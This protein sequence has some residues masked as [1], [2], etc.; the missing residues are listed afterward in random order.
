MYKKKV[1]CIKPSKGSTIQEQA[2]DCFYSIEKSLKENQVDIRNV[3]KQTIFI[4][5]VDNKHFYARK[6][7]LLIA[8]EGFYKSLLPPTGIVGQLP[9][10]DIFLAIELTL[11]ANRRK[12]IKISRK[13]V[14]G[15]RYLTVQYP[16]FKE[17]Y[18]AGLTAGETCT[19]RLLQAKEAFEQMKKILENENLNF[20]DV[21]RQWNY[22][23]NITGSTIL[24][25]GEKQNYQI[26]NDT[27]AIYYGRSTFKNGYPAAT[28]IGMN[29]GGVILEFIAVEGSKDMAI[30][31][32]KNPDQVDAHQYG[33]TVLVGDPIKDMPQKAPPK[34]ERA[35]LLAKDNLHFIYV[36]GTAAIRGQNTAAEQD[37]E[38]QT[39]VTIENIA[40]LISRENLKKYGTQLN[41]DTNPLSYLRVY[42]K[43]K[44]DL[45]KVKKICTAYFKDVPSLYLVADICRDAL[46]VEIEGTTISYQ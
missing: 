10:D 40:K 36:S 35:K 44:I 20:S 28:G 45:P 1:I 38:A 4:N 46:L 6:K 26:F 14:D 2:A 17:V 23:E 22:I 13:D 19:S 41:H 33:Q 16:D 37:V 24:E 34:F 9:E 12:G 43:N 8:L 29:C 31:P 27:R 42:V 3:L 15:L 32:I 39:L 21:V 30:I 5:A 18:G 11:L 7:E 25:D